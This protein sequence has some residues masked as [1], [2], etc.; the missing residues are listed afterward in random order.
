MFN[1]LLAIIVDA[2][3]GA[4]DE[5]RETISIAQDASHAVT[6]LVYNL[7]F[8]KGKKTVS[9]Q[10]RLARAVSVLSAQACTR[11]L[12]FI[13]GKVCNPRLDRAE[14]KLAS[15]KLLLCAESTSQVLMRIQTLLKSG[16]KKPR[17]WTL[18]RTKV[19]TP[20]Q[21]TCC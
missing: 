10:Q 20:T 13:E 11:Y 18:S 14:M 21:A 12:I 2:Y 9:S 8:L 19:V 7:A 16:E 1:I 15:K 5:S 3:G 6:R 4:A 17:T